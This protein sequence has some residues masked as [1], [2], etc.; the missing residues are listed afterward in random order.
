VSEV[1]LYWSG[2]AG[3]QETLEGDCGAAADKSEGWDA[4]EQ[5]EVKEGGVA[6][7]TSGNNYLGSGRGWGRAFQSQERFMTPETP[8]HTYCRPRRRSSPRTLSS[9][10]ELELDVGHTIQRRGFKRWYWWHASPSRWTSPAA[11]QL[12]NMHQPNLSPKTNVGP[13]WQGGRAG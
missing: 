5:D 12:C 8:K 13:R 6:R 9:D 11:P 4:T 7:A 2:G 10:L 1:P 3:C